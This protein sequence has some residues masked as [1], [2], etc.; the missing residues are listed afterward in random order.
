MTADRWDGRRA[1]TI[2]GGSGGFGRAS[3]RAL[4]SLP[5]DGPV[6]LV[7]V[8]TAPPRPV[9]RSATLTPTPIAALAAE[10]GIEPLLAPQRLRDSE[11]VAAVL[12]RRPE[13]L[14]VADFG[15]IVPEPLL[16]V[17]LGALNLHPSR[18]PRHRGASPIPA[19]I[20]AGDADTAVT[21]I[22]MDA[23][24]DSGPI[25]AVS[26]PVEVAARVTSPEL[27]AALEPVAA[28]LLVA[29]LRPWLAGEIE[30][31]PQASEGVTTTRRLRRDDGR[32]DPSRPAFVLERA[33]R[34][35]RPWPGTFVETEE[36]ER[37]AVLRAALDAS[38]ADDTPGR[39]VVDGDGLA[40]T[41]VDGRLR[42]LE[43][44]PASGRPMPADA[45]LR[46]RPRFGEA[47]VSVR[48][49]TMTDR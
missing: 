14:V 2:F 16:D 18:L 13:L 26:E 25:V 48:G 40:L 42:L 6:E 11:A 33:V 28:D 7:G 15:Q 45:F 21:L 49:A 8:L 30:P 38:H 23:G 22:R 27:E 12:D 41:T 47:S 44:R 10:L 4:A 24:V 37:V 39:L 31:L 43:L 29:S 3:L 5:N 9:G 17:S 34:A 20:L 32:L 46:G 1:R 36:G 19:T 35:F